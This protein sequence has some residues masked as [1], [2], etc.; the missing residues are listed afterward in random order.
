MP[1][2]DEGEFA[3][4]IHNIEKWLRRVESLI[5]RPTGSGTFH[6]AVTVT[7]TATVNLTLT[8]Q[9]IKADVIGGSGHVIKDEAGAGLTARTNLNFTGAG[10]TAT[11]NAGTDST[12]VT[13][14]G[15]GGGTLDTL[16]PIT[17]PVLGDFS[18]VNQDVAS[19]DD[20]Y[21]SIYLSVPANNAINFNLL[22][23]SAPTP[24]Y[25]ITAWVIPH[26][27]MVNYN[28]VGLCFRE[29]AT[30][31]IVAF[32]TN[33]N[34]ND[35][36]HQKQNSP[37]SY[38]SSYASYSYRPSSFG[39]WLRLQDDNTNRIV[40]WSADGR[41]FFVAGTVGRTDFLT[42]DQVGFF[43]QSRNATYPAGITIVSWLET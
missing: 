25:T 6:D 10:V 32:G 12:D 38:N 1:N 7:D 11:D 3:R 24:P 26:V 14:P 23:K 39:L 20:T 4:R 42:A 37:T 2:R 13:I 29:S 35:L 16:F 22:V 19:V 40:S 36:S 17:T 8:G 15:G 18:W 21:G 41:H 33:Y 28:Y 9:D 30:G 5:I 43:V 31:E 27:S 34:T